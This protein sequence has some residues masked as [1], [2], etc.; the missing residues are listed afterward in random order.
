MPLKLER[1]VK[2]VYK[3]SPNVNPWAVCKSSLGL[4]KIKKGGK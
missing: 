2:K 4:T 3:N 1:C